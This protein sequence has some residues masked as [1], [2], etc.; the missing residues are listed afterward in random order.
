MSRLKLSPGISAMIAAGI[1]THV[2]ALAA[3]HGQA[4]EIFQL[5]KDAA[6]ATEEGDEELDLTDPLGLSTQ[7]AIHELEAAVHAS[8][9]TSIGLTLATLDAQGIEVRPLLS[10]R[11]HAE[12]VARFNT[13]GDDDPGSRKPQ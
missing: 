8:A 13:K 3:C 2:G 9:L 11:D 5:Q 6:E 10:V 1:E 12:S 7:R 4:R